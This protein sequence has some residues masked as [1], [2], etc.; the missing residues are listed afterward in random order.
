MTKLQEVRKLVEDRKQR[1]RE[2]HSALEDQ[3]KIAGLEI[4]DP[5]MREYAQARIP[6]L[7]IEYDRVHVAWRDAE[8]EEHR[9]TW[10][11]MQSRAARR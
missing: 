11:R 1:L 7:Q 5:G 2:L 10:P 3:K 4:A 9:L 6:V 8:A